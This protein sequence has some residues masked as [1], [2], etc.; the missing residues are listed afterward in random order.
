MAILSPVLEVLV[1][2]EGEE[3][4]ALTLQLQTVLLG[5]LIQ[6]AEAALEIQQLQLQILHH[7]F[8]NHLQVEEII[9]LIIT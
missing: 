7:F 5:L 2:L 3:L 1:D 6:A 8:N 9:F 4:E